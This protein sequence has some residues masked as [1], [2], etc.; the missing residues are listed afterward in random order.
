MRFLHHLWTIS[1]LVLFLLSACTSTQGLW[2]TAST[3]ATVTFNSDLKST[4]T[5]VA[6]NPNEAAT[7]L[8]ATL[9]PTNTPSDHIVLYT[10]DCGLYALPPV[11]A[12][13]DPA[14]RSIYSA[15]TDCAFDL[16]RYFIGYAPLLSPDARRLL[17]TNPYETWVADFPAGKSQR[18]LSEQIAATWDPAG[19]RITYMSGDKLYTWALDTATSPQA[20]FQ[21]PDLL[22]AFARWSPDGKWNCCCAAA[23]TSACAC[24]CA[25]VS[26]SAC[27]RACAC[28]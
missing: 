13:N 4:S 25:G 11:A 10:R 5:P 8:P 3:P 15:V 16:P 20:L 1:G 21:H 12:L 23:C 19:E 18:L 9:L 17:I 22:A 27:A 2:A 7:P 14:M 6:I 24:A 26:E 28:A